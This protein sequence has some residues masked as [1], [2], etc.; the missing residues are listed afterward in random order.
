MDG[1]SPRK[2]RAAGRALGE[3]EPPPEH[4]ESEGRALGLAEP[5]R[6][7]APETSAKT[8]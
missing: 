7:V 2:S 6:A 8:T 4:E 1:A 3:G 5:G